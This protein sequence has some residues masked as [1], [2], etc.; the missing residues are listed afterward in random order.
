MAREQRVGGRLAEGGPP[1]VA[2]AGVEGGEAGLG[3]EAAAPP[4]VG[5]ERPVGGQP[6]DWPPCWAA[7]VCRAGVGEWIEEEKNTTQQALKTNKIANQ[8]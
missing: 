3:G 6:G 4:P 7:G 1:A 2:V 8:K 5:E